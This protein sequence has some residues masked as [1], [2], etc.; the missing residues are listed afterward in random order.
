M[1]KTLTSIALTVAFPLVLTGCVNFAPTTADYP[2]ATKQTDPIDHLVDWFLADND[3]SVSYGA[4]GR[5]M[6]KLDDAIHTDESS[7]RVH[8]EW[9]SASYRIT[10]KPAPQL[11][12]SLKNLCGAIGGE[13]VSGKTELLWCKRPED[14]AP[15]FGFTAK[16]YSTKKCRVY[17]T[18]NLL[19]PGIMVEASIVTPLKDEATGALNPLDTTWLKRTKELGFM[20]HKK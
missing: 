4:L 14:N 7:R 19:A 2:D 5:K 9:C 13:V 16:A 6:L 18:D 12:D 11:S 17:N 20:P 3:N 10:E 15:V 1:T 8:V